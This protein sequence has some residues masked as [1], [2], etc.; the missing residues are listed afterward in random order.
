M[1]CLITNCHLS[2][3]HGSEVFSL[4]IAHELKRRG[5]QVFIYSPELGEF[6][7]R[8]MKDEF[9]TFKEKASMEG[10]RMDVAILQHLNKIQ[11]IEYFQKLILPTTMATSRKNILAVCHGIHADPE[12]PVIADWLEGCQ[13]VCISS[14]IAR[15]YSPYENWKVIKQPIGPEWFEMA[16]KSFPEKPLTVLWAS[17]RFPVPA[18]LTWACHEM[19]INLKSTAGRTV[20]L[21]ELIVEYRGVDLVIGTGRWIYQAMAMG[22]PCIVANHE[23]NL[24]YVNDETVANQEFYNMTLRNPSVHDFPWEMFIGAYN[25]EAAQSMHDYALEN[26]HVSKV[27]DHL[28]EDCE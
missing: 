24:W 7:Q 11:S 9:I 1:K 27:V 13:R 20:W 15:H 12:K 23:K 6:W 4:T 3:P 25:T 19:D 28:L 14:E 5:H 21:D 2:A 16:R 26:Y 17:H 8:Y 10:Y 22:I 18:S